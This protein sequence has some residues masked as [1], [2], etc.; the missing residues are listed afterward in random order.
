MR[1]QLLAV[2]TT[3]WI[4]AIGSLSSAVIALALALGLK[5]WIVRPRV[6]IVLR[7]PSDPEQFSDRIV[8]KRLETGDVGAF[9]RVR[10]DN[11]GRS[12]ARNVCVRLL[13]THR[14]EPEQTTWIR[15]R[16]ELDGRLLQPSNQLST[17]PNLVDVFPHSDRVIDL[18]SVDLARADDGKAPVFI[19][20]GHPWPP[21]EA[22][23]LEPGI[24]RLELMVCGDNVRA[25]R[26]FIALAFD[27]TK[28]ESDETAIW[29]HFRVR[30]PFREMANPAELSSSGGDR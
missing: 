8:T 9:V 15:A 27:G 23:T 5:D 24:W 10:L 30:G 22:N 16:P 14:W 1:T 21:N 29:E 28:P 26:T 18:A 12:T 7:D 20:I 2:E 11:R 25:D 4:I 6:R 3:Q 17:E 19:E 13:K